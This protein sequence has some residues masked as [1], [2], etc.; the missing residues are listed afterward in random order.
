MLNIQDSDGFPKSP[1]KIIKEERFMTRKMITFTAIAG[2]IAACIVIGGCARR[3]FLS[4]SPEKRAEFIVKRL[5]R[6]L[7]LT[8]EQVERLNTIKDEILARSRNFK[9]DRKALF[10]QAIA[11][12]KSD[13]LDKN[14]LNNW[15]SRREQ[16]RNELKPFIV[17]KIIEFHDMLTPEQKNK[18]AEKMEKLHRYWD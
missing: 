6:T 13:K 7:D 8:K 5:T 12:V 4:K 1:G 16:I 3:H 14:A 18:L 10:N 17:D 2:V 9:S 15:I 11:L